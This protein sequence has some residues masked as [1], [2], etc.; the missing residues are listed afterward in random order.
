MSRSGREPRGLARDRAQGFCPTQRV[1]PG[2]GGGG[3]PGPRP[4]L[5]TGLH[6]CAELGGCWTDPVLNNKQNI[7]PL[8]SDMKTDEEKL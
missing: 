7:E 5:A 8:D 1:W 4:P 2:M 6:Y 3:T